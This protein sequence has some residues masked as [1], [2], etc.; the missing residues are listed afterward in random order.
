[1]EKQGSLSQGLAEKCKS[2]R[3]SLREAAARTGLSHSTIKDIIDGSRP[4]PETI[5]KL[6]QGFGG[7]GSQRLALED[8]LLVLAGCRT[9]RPDGEEPSE[10]MAQLMDKVRQFSEPRLKMM[11][12]FADFLTEIDGRG[13]NGC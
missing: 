10:S 7:N 5:R 11:V 2:G 4:L 1:M 8:Y 3:L 9:E 12:H 13:S 6:A